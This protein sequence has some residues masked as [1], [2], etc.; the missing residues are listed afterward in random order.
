MK[1]IK[2]TRGKE[3]WIDDCDYERIS[4]HQ[5]HA[6][7]D[8]NTWYAKTY[9]E[10]K[11][12]LLHRFILNPPDNVEIDHRDGNALDNRR[13]NIRE[14]SHSENMHNQRPQVN[15]SSRYKGVSWD[16]SRSKWYAQIRI[17]SKQKSLGHFSD[18]NEAAKVYNEAA[19][20][21]FGQFAYIN[22]I[23]KAGENYPLL[24]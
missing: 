4:R 2:L 15:K 5:W 1:I 9:I 21:L 3:T 19:K 10:G 18:E 20:K 12:V 17:N 11:I 13:F 23:V 14:C 16:K 22:I 8:Y 7:K 24:A 6:Q